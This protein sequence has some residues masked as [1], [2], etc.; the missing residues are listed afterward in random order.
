MHTWFYQDYSHPTLHCA[1]SVGGCLGPVW[2]DV[3]GMDMGDILFD[4]LGNLTDMFYMMVILIATISVGVNGRSIS[5][6]LMFVYLRIVGVLV[7]CSFL[8]A[9]VHGRTLFSPGG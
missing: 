5:S 3:I 8:T 4:I 9:I 2:C 6:L 1:S 7:S